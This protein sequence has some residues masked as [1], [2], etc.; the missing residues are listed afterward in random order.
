MRPQ[1]RFY[2][3]FFAPFLFPLLIL[4]QKNIDFS[5]GTQHNIDASSFYPQVVLR[6]TIGR[7][8]KLPKNPVFSPSASGWDSDDVAD[9][10]VLVRA[11]SILLFYDGSANGHYALGYAVRDD[12]GWNWEKRRQI[13]KPD[14][15]DW[16]QFHLIA[17][18]L[19]PGKPN[20]LLYNGNQTDSELNYRMGL[21]QKSA[22]N[23]WQF[24]AQE[25]VFTP[26]SDQWDFA[27]NAYQDVVYIADEKKYKMW[28]S[29]FYGP[30]AHIGLAYSENGY[31]WKKSS[32][33]PVFKSAPGVI[34]P[35]VIYNGQTYTMYYTQLVLERGFATSIHKAQSIDGI[36]W[37]DKTEVL[38]AETRWEGYRLM[39]PNISFFEEQVHLF[40][41]AQKGSSW[42]IGE[43]I[44]N[45][46]F[47]SSGF[48][49]SADLQRFEAIT[50]I[51]EMPFQTTINIFFINRAGQ[52]RKA[53]FIAEAQTMRAGVFTT[54]I[55]TPEDFIATKIRLE[56]STE[57]QHKSPVIYQLTP[58]FK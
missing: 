52:K 14:Q 11:D 29:G 16:R 13:L 15:T 19:V 26:E 54:R 34:A 12:A 49:E 48:W 25:P 23:G 22:Q 2:L 9:P 56:L 44:A 4:A 35:E 24:A 6:H 57:H 8:N 51:Y 27:G 41:C 28:Y 20:L 17:P 30:F 53:D 10:F 3:L 1:I 32:Q 36:N 40:Y 18:T 37:Q 43:A 38:K 46:T 58:H 33:Q 7:F 45:A 55:H 21:A 42:R 39:H 47:K 5:Q 50:F 31:Q